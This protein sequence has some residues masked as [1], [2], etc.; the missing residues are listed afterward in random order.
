MAWSVALRMV[1][2]EGGERLKKAFWASV[3]VSSLG[4]ILYL[5]VASA[6]MFYR[7]VLIL[8]TTILF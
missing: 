4:F 2:G 7:K 8:V 6:D 3:S 1:R 5:Y